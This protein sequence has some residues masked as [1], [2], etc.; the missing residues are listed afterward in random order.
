LK[1]EHNGR[2]SHL[3][4]VIQIYIYGGTVSNATLDKIEVFDPSS[5]TITII[6]GNDGSYVGVERL[7]PT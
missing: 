6:V 2:I 5:F 4:L 3:F 7:K 1:S